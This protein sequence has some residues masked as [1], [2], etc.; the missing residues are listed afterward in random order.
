MRRVVVGVRAEAVASP[1][2]CGPQPGNPPPARP[3]QSPTEALSRHRLPCPCRTRPRT[4]PRGYPGA[5]ERQKLRAPAALPHRPRLHAWDAEC[6]IVCIRIG[7]GV[8]FP[9][10][11]QTGAGLAPRAAMP[12]ERRRPVYESR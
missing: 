3:I 2:P 1:A 5:A 9:R 6:D 12:S 4:A 7:S 11:S 8:C 10:T